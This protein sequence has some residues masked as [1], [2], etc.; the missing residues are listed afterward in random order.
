[1]L[2]LFDFK[3]IFFSNGQLNLKK[4]YLS[5]KRCHYLYDLV[6]LSFLSKVS[7]IFALLNEFINFS[8]DKAIIISLNLLMYILPRYKNHNKENTN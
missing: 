4:T 5:N 1:M 3:I 8:L 7:L 6:K 2:S